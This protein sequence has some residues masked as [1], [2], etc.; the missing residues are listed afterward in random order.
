MVVIVPW[1]PVIMITRVS[2]VRFPLLDDVLVRRGPGEN[3]RVWREDAVSNFTGV[4]PVHSG[5]YS[6]NL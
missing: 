1:T 6:S 3:L 2:E 5:I 4:L